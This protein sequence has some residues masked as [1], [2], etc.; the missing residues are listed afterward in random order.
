ME[1]EEQ[2]GEILCGLQITEIKYS[3]SGGGDCGETRL[4]QVVH[5]DGQATSPRRLGLDEP[6]PRP[7]EDLADIDLPYTASV[8]GR[9]RLP[10]P[11]LDTGH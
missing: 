7:R 2:L 6:T 5:R 1:I 9:T 3:L 8:S 4:E 10:R 11:I